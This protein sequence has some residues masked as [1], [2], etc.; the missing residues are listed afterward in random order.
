MTYYGESEDQKWYYR[1]KKKDEH[2][3][4]SLEYNHSLKG[5]VIISEQVYHNDKV[6]CRFASFKSF[7]NFSEWYS[8]VKDKIYFECIRGDKSQKIYFDVD[9]GDS[10]IEKG[11]ITPEES[12]DMIRELVENVIEVCNEYLHTKKVEKEDVMIFTTPS[13]YNSDGSK[14]KKISYHVVVTNFYV[15]SNLHNQE[16]YKRVTSMM[17]EKYTQ[18]ID[19]SMYSSLQQFRIMYSH[20]LGH[21]DR[22]KGLHS[23]SEWKSSMSKGKRKKDAIMNSLVTNVKGCTL[24]KFEVE[25]KKKVVKRQVDIDEDMQGDIEDMVE[26]T[27]GDTYEIGDDNGEGLIPLIRRN[28]GLVCPICVKHRESKEASIHEN[29]DGYLTIRDGN[30]FFHCYREKKDSLVI[31]RVNEK[32]TFIGKGRK[33]DIKNIITKKEPGEKPKKK[34]EDSFDRLELFREVKKEKPHEMLMFIGGGIKKNNS[35]KIFRI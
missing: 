23:M 2:D 12:E 4:N 14:K 3:H 1:L 24:I 13:G 22:I 10:F 30:V 28:V 19:K 9:I 15:E 7:E 34:K 21:N 32:F 29:I 20:K 35:K 6:V 11:D 18:H 31:G 16:I 5:G 27:F 26:K 17:D 8:I 25:E 33:V